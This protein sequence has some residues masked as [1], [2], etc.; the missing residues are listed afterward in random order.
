VH[1]FDGTDL[2]LPPEDQQELCE[3]L[4]IM[5]GNLRAWSEDR[6]ENEEE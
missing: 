5:R 4:D 1:E 6:A 3:T 2:D